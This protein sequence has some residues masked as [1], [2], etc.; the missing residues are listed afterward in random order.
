MRAHHT[1]YT[2]DISQRFPKFETAFR[3]HGAITDGFIGNAPTQCCDA[4][5]MK[6][7]IERIWKNCGDTDPLLEE[8]PM[9]PKWYC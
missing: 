2:H 6:E 5:I 7:V 3:Y 4:R 8:K 9:P 1:D